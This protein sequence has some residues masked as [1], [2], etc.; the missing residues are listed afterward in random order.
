MNAIHDSS[1]TVARID[2][3]GSGHKV[4]ALFGAIVATG[5]DSLRALKAA[6]EI[7]KIESEHFETRV[8]L[9]SGPLLC[10]EVGSQH[11]CEFTVM[12]NAVNM[13]A[14]LMTKADPAGLLL[15]EQFYQA[16]AGFAERIRFK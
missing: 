7:S 14:R 1:G 2:P 9:T 4:L 11:R 3:F 10:G 6:V 16:V 5:N 12:G 15:D 13:A 8:G